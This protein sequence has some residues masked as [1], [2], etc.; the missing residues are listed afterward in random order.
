MTFC[1]GDVVGRPSV[2]RRPFRVRAVLEERADA[3]VLAAICG[4]VAGRP[5]ILVRL[6]YVCSTLGQRVDAHVVA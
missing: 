1:F 4:D 5:F 3:R 2:L 6:V